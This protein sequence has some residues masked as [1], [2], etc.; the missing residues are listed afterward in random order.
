MKQI[1]N[2]F[3]ETSNKYVELIEKIEKT[4]R[5]YNGIELYP[6]EIHTLV[7]IYENKD[8]NLTS[9]AQKL[10]VT[11]GAIF[12]IINKLEDKQLLSRYKK[13]DNNKNTY[14]EVTQMGILACEGHE[15]FHKTVFGDPSNVFT[16][17]T[18]ENKDVILG[19]L[20][21]SKDYLTQHIEKI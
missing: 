8:I 11:K 21:L 9:I 16:Q 17:F 14:F 20:Q 19:F 5:L 3:I 7:F 2:E 18:N 10:G 13:S 1:I 15:I 6:S 12:K 4:K